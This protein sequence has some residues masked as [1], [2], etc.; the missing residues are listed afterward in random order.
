MKPFI[1]KFAE[2]QIDSPATVVHHYSFEKSLN[3]VAVDGTTKALIELG[4][5]ESVVSTKTRVAR[6][7][8]DVH[9]ELLEASTKTKVQREGDDNSYPILELATKTM[10]KKE[11]DD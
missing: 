8:D 7:S 3:V 4:S 1:L 6:E 11:S 2:K 5:I 9:S 10:V